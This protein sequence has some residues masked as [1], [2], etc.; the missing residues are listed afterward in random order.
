M[1]TCSG[2]RRYK[3]DV[4]GVCKTMEIDEDGLEYD[5]SVKMWTVEYTEVEY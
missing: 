5:C 1:V 2:Q 3:D 4:Y